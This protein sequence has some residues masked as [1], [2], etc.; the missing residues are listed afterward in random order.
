MKT[1]ALICSFLVVELLPLRAQCPTPTP[2][3]H[4]SAVAISPYTVRFQVDPASPP[5]V[6]YWAEKEINDGPF[7]LVNTS[8]PN[9]IFIDSNKL[10]PR[11]R[12]CYRT[13]AKTAA[14]QCE[15]FS[16]YTDEIMVT[17][18]DG[19]APYEG[20][21]EPPTNLI[22]EYVSGS[23]VMLR[24]TPG[25]FPGVV[26]QNQVFRV[27]RSQ[28]GVTYVAVNSGGQPQTDRNP[29]HGQLYYRVRAFNPFGWA[30]GMAFN[31]QPNQ[32]NCGTDFTN[33]V[34]ITVP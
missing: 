21:P 6:G 31:C 2:P 17:M 13:R 20:A 33:V 30:T 28:D 15:R 19:P 34:I 4:S 23:G 7:V 32:T 9:G 22:A 10:R 1:I 29:P 5:T 26:G 27:E 18:P 14:G 25:A 11:D 16:A 8:Y 3:P 24:W 12:V